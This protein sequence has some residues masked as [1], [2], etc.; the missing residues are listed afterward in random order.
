[1]ASRYIPER[2]SMGGNPPAATA[3]FPTG[4]SRYPILSALIGPCS[5]CGAAAILEPLWDGTR[6][7]CHGC[8]HEVW[9]ADG[10]AQPQAL[11]ILG[12][13]MGLWRAA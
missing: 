5:R 10:D 1:M 2:A 9:L 13:L 11:D 4:N 6:V 8:R 12:R 7:S 3:T